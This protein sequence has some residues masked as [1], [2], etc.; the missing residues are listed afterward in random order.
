L[1][2]AA[3]VMRFD[4]RSVLGRSILDSPANFPPNSR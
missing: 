1:L 3:G 4:A 2:A